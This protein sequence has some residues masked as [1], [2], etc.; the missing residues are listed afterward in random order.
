MRRGLLP[1]Q[2]ITPK[3]WLRRSVRVLRLMVVVSD[4]RPGIAIVRASKGAGRDFR[5]R[6]DDNRRREQAPSSS[7][8]RTKG[9]AEAGELFRV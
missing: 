6:R 1:V 3:H 2:A 9:R 4:G 8:W 7:V 5:V